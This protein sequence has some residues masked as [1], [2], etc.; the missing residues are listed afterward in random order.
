LYRLIN[1]GDFLEAK[2][3]LG[4]W[5]D[6]KPQPL[7]RRKKRLKRNEIEYSEGN[8][9]EIYL[10]CREAVINGKSIFVL[11]DGL[12]LSEH[13]FIWESIKFRPDRMLFV[14]QLMNDI[15]DNEPGYLDVNSTLFYD[16]CHARAREE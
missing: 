12:R 13:D 15:V 9:K 5:D 10:K 1:G 14:Y 2:K 6:S 8:K 4:F 16:Y 11:R 3:A 7:P